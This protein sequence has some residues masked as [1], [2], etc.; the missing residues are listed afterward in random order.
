[1]DIASIFGALGNAATGGVLGAVGGIAQAGL[2]L[3]QYKQQAAHE[4]DMKKIDNQHEEARW[5]HD[6]EL[7]KYESQSKQ[8]L[9]EIDAGARK[10]VAD[11]GALSASFESDKRSYSTEAGA[12][13][14]PRLFAFV[15][16]IRGITRPF[17]TVY[18]D[19]LFTALA[20]WVTWELVKSY[21]SFWK[22]GKV[23]VETF[24]SLIDAVIFMSTTATMWWF[25]AR[26]IERK[27]IK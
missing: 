10:D 18:L 16:F 17:I 15:D 24:Q 14:F 26:G 6:L 1:M 19:M 12:S 21:P 22:D 7:A 4:V 11:A 13:Q 3:W 8:V 20:V 9:A 23:L 27:A 5:G 25:A 2:N